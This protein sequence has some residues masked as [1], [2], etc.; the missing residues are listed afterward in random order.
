M[1]I[2]SSDWINGNFSWFTISDFSLPFPLAVTDVDVNDTDAGGN[3]TTPYLDLVILGIPQSHPLN[4][5]DTSQA[6]VACGRRVREQ[7]GS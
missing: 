4:R 6:Q 3:Q 1:K 2:W 7:I 5:R